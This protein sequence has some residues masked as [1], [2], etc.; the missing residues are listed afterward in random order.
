MKPITLVFSE[1]VQLTVSSIFSS[2]ISSSCMSFVVWNEGAA[3][4]R[5]GRNK[6]LRE[7]GLVYILDFS[8]A[9]METKLC[10][11]IFY[12]HQFKGFYIKSCFYKDFKLNKYIFLFTGAGFIRSMDTVCLY[13]TSTILTKLLISE[14]INTLF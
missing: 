9:G 2:D 3:E 6:F 8:N 10:T 4:G 5:E 14:R 12:I 7:R 1:M 13:D 11:N